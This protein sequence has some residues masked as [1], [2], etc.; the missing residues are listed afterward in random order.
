M[1]LAD[2]VDFYS[3]DGEAVDLVFGLMV[4][5]EL[6]DED[7]AD[8]DSLTLLLRD[9]ALCARLRAATSSKELGEALFTGQIVPTP[10]R[11][12]AQQG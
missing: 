9:Q 2:A 3:N 12:S 6:S 11:M 8:I 1:K 10:K 4:P 5:T 7:L